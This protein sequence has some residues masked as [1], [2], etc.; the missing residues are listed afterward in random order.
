MVA[1]DVAAFM[2][3]CDF[4]TILTGHT[5]AAKTI[6]ARHQLLTGWIEPSEDVVF[7]EF[8]DSAA[9]NR[10]DPN[11]FAFTIPKYGSP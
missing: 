8:L 9:R 3:S 10:I 4:N 2:P 1:C 7:I 5:E 11:V 6:Q